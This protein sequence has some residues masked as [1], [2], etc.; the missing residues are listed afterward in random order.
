MNR[1]PEHQKRIRHYH[2][3]GHVHDWKWSSAPCYMVDPP[4]QRAGLPILHSPPAEWLKGI[5]DTIP[6]DTIPT[7]PGRFRIPGLGVRGIPGIG[8]S[9][10]FLGIPGHGE[11]FRGHEPIMGV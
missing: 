11:G 10:G 7:I 3:P 5:F 4:Q 6:G 2:D 1:G 9:W 8:D